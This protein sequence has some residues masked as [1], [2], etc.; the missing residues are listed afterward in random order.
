MRVLAE[1][2]MKGRAQAV[3]I[4]MIATGSVLFAWIGAAVIALV[5]LRQGIK[6]GSYVLLWAMLP[7]LVLASMGDTTPVMTLLGAMLVA[8]V[9]RSSGSWS[10]AL[11]ATVAS[12]VIT[13]LVLLTVGQGYIE[14]LS[15]LLSET[16]AQ[17]ASQSDQASPLVTEKPTPPQI[18]GLLGLSNA[19]T[20]TLCVI[21]A[22]WWQGILYNPGGF[23]DEFKGLRLAP[24]LAVVLLLAGL[25][26]STLGSDYRLWA[27][28]FAVPFMFAGFALVHGLV[29]QKNM[30]GGW[31]TVFYISWLLLDPVKALLI[32]AAVVDSWIDIRKRLAER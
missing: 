21:L 26:L 32:G 6:H 23:G 30:K 9:L 19:F 4:S 10:W 18:A 27:V 2:V 20:V 25:V 31:L 14:E 16:L 15:K 29:A 8:M 22:R 12:G 11:V 7:A 3:I 13:G 5:T 24:Q 1:Y 28:I 17:L